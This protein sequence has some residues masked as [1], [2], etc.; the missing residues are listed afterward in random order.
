MSSQVVRALAWGIRDDCPNPLIGVSEL[1]F[2]ATKNSNAGMS[3]DGED[4]LAM[5][6]LG[7]SVF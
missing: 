3:P 1:S 5:S 2:A 7:W 4:F 6:C